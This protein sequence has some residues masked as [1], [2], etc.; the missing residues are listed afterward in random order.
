MTNEDKQPA[1]GPTWDDLRRLADEIQLK[2]H[3]AGMDARAQWKKLEPRITAL[4]H[5]IT[6]GTE[7]VGQAVNDQL[8]S[9]GR[10]IR[11]LA[12]KVRTEVKSR[13]P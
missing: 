13:A 4:E 6:T 3:L 10:S 9:L 8:T 12:E 7:R 5:Q 1:T 2:V 11:D